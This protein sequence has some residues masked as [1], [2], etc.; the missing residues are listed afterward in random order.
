MALE[1]PT[2]VC[3]QTPQGSEPDTLDYALSSKSRVIRLVLQ[4]A[5]SH[6][7][8][9][10]EE[11][12]VLRAFLEELYMSVCKDSKLIPGLTEMLP[13]LGKMVKHNSEDADS[14]QKKH[15]VLLRQFSMGDERLQKRQPIRSSDEIL[16][17][18]YCLDHTYTTIRV[19]L[20]ASVR[21]VI[22]TVADKLG[23]DQDLLLVSL[24][25]AG[26]K[27]VL[28]PDDVSVFS[29]LSINGRLFVCHRDQMDSLTPLPE[30]E[31]PSL[32]TMGSF[33]LMSSKDLAYQMTVYDWELFN[34]VHEH[35]LIYHTFGR[36]KFRKTT[37]NLDLFLRR[38]NEVQLWVVTEVCLCAQLSKRVQLLKKFIKIA[39][40]CKENKNLNSFLAIVMG[41]GNPA[42][43][44]LSQTW[45][46]LPSKF[47]KVYG[48][49]E[50]LMDPS[51]NHRAYRLTVA[52][53]DP[54]VIPLMPLLI[55]DMTFTHEGN[56]TLVDSL[57]NFEKMR[58]I[59]DTVRTVR[60]C[61]SQ[62][63]S[64]PILISMP[65]RLLL[66]AVCSRS[67]CVC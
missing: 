64:K 61:R 23:T 13:E 66:S 50:S 39:A 63:F 57:V 6:G 45:E 37:A 42:V 60:Y 20:A 38:F 54:P 22:S 30:Q 2:P 7:D 19:P 44:R 59:A 27:T 5:C 35:E 15:K 34:C 8:Q 24:S 55:K 11:E 52:K 53:L 18:V 14:S 40:H 16:F 31:G 12:Q 43:S 65:Q 49:F 4:W 58:M 36:H 41:M 17:K 26:D 51:R 32:G 33:E 67:C 28:K 46:K 10:P 62:P 47:K 56:K 21:E 3:A 48:E 25:S 9:L 1:G 29:T